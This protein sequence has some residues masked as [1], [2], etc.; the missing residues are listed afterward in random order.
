[1]TNPIAQI[2]A[3]LATIY[4]VLNVFRIVNDIGLLWG[5]LYKQ[6]HKQ[7]EINRRLR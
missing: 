2:A 1:M 4:I 5:G 7:Q 3:F 6:L